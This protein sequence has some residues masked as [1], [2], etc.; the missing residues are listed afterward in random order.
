MGWRKFV[1]IGGVTLVLSAC[2]GSAAAP[3]TPEPTVA[4]VIAPTASRS[5]VP[6][7]SA[8]AASPV[9]AA[10]AAAATKPAA[11]TEVKKQ[12]MV[13]VGNTDGEG[14][15]LRKTPVM[16]DRLK[17]Y[18]DG[19]PLTIVGDDVDGDGQHWKHVKVP[20]GTEGYVP[21]MYTVDTAP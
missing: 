17:A 15:F 2:G 19:T 1:G 14:V 21:A 18:A 4:P 11:T 5:A 7:P 20:D 16:A 9:V 3:A 13:W 10:A 12:D 6:S 8:A